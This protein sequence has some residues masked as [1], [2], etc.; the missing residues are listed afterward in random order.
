MT[1]SQLL[2]LL[3]ETLGHD[4][5][6]QFVIPEV[7]SLAEDPVFRVRKS[8]A[9][10]LHSICKVG[11]EHELLER[12]MP[13]FVRLSKDDMYRVRRACAESLTDISK[14]VSDDVR[15]GV[16]VEIFLRL[17]QDPSRMVKQSVLQQSGTFIATLPSLY[18]SSTILQHYCSMSYYPTGDISMDAELR[19]IC[20]FCFPAVLQ[21]IGKER[22]EE[23]R[24]VYRNLTQSR[25]AG[26]KQT[27]AHSLHEVAL[28]LQ[29]PQLVEE[30][31]VAV[32]EDMIQGVEPVQMG[33]IKH[34][35]TFLRMLPELC[36]V[37]YLPL[38]H[39]ILHSTNPFNWRLRQ[40]L[41]VQLP[42]LARLPAKTELYQTLFPLIL[43]LLQ[44]PVA[45][46]R[47]A[48]FPGVTSLIATL[49]DLSCG[50][51]ANV[52]SSMND[53]NGIV[54]VSRHYLENLAKSINSFAIGEKY[55]LRQ[56]WV[57]LCHRLLWDLPRYLFECYFIEGILLLTRDR[58]TNVR[59]TVSSFLAGW[60]IGG[61]AIHA[62]TLKPRKDFSSGDE[63]STS[64]VG[65]RDSDN[66][67][68]KEESRDVVNLAAIP[69]IED[70]PYSWLLARPDVQ[71]CVA[72]L[73][74]DDVDVYLNMKHLQPA[75]P[76]LEFKSIKCRGMK[77]A[78]GGNDSIAINPPL[79]A[80]WKDGPLAKKE[81]ELGFLTSSSSQASS[82][83]SDG[84]FEEA[85]AAAAVAS[86]SSVSSTPLASQGARSRGYSGSSVE[87]MSIQS[88]S[89]GSDQS[90]N[91]SNS[92][93][94]GS[95]SSSNSS[96]VSRMR[97]G[98]KDG[99][100]ASLN[101]YTPHPASTSPPVFS[102]TEL[103]EAE[104]LSPTDSNLEDEFMEN[105]RMLHNPNPPHYSAP[106]VMGGYAHRPK[107]GS[108]D[109]HSCDTSISDIEMEMDK[110]DGIFT[111]P[112]V[113]FI[114]P[115]LDG[116]EGTGTDEQRVVAGTTETAA[117]DEAEETLSNSSSESSLVSPHSNGHAEQ[118]PPFPP[119]VLE[120]EMSAG[121]DITPVD[122]SGATV[123][124]VSTSSKSG[125]TS[126]EVDTIISVDHSEDSLT[127]NKVS[128][129]AVD[130]AN[131]TESIT[132]FVDSLDMS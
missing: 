69:S 75:F 131:D 53:E 105:N 122:I 91:S 31:L 3:A 108:F 119:S 65:G 85:A 6:K 129:A 76:F 74:A 5:C 121:V 87:D 79:Q 56:L 112:V 28:I 12:L 52:G 35:A 49:Y 43:I 68:N 109:E 45:S 47:V 37:S 9:L 83:Q 15:L 128:A 106:G 55:Q 63:S 26:I 130:V 80:L 127:T 73:A 20:A 64:C 72:R 71:Q 84:S 93:N 126:A 113:K 98:S 81:S 44:D 117:E 46:V 24:E 95:S 97:S 48:S 2:N 14:N 96:G 29:D 78:P 34:L 118:M 38:L 107:S 62:R 67:K 58:V 8:A 116:G 120:E 124:R 57:E 82:R 17:T 103:S 16:L 61:G 42:E 90:M 70:T 115:P 77:I 51:E 25:S 104:E 132:K 30:E 33:I 125:S 89:P 41:A 86:S 10:N 60:Q 54:A 110:I 101:L 100:A 11:G 13:A 111:T 114:P 99:G 66:G 40:S 1:A 39:D 92:S 94:S 32:F 59:I 36:R 102:T 88:S 23:V 123:S 27:L 19:Q 21:T 18:V 7:V 22:W 4:Y 50:D